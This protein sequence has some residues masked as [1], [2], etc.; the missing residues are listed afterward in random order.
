M[1]NNV[2]AQFGYFTVF[3]FTKNPRF[4]EHKLSDRLGIVSRTIDFGPAGRFFFYTS[5]GQTA[6]TEE[7]IALKIGFVRTP[8][9]SSLSAQHLLDRKLVSPEGVDQ[10]ALRGNALVGCFS[11][12][13]A[14][15]SIFKTLL[16]GLPLYY[17]VNEDGL[18]CSDRLR[19]LVEILDR[20]ELD[21]AAI[22]QHF[23]LL[24]TVGSQTY[25]RNVQ[26][27]RPGECLKWEEGGLKVRL[28]KDFRSFEEDPT[29]GSTDPRSPLIHQRLKDVIGA[30]ISSIQKSGSDFGNLLSGGVDSS[31]TQLLINENLPDAQHRSFSFLMHA[32]SFE[33]EVEYAKQAQLVFNTEHVFVDV[34]PKDYPDLLVR[35]IEILG[36]PVYMA[37]DPCKIALAE[38][39]A[40]DSNGP[41]YFFH[42]QGGDSV[43]GTGLARKIRWLELA[44]GIP[45]SALI[46]GSAGKLLKP[47][48]ARQS[49]MLRKAAIILKYPNHLMA[50]INTIVANA[51]YDLAL[52][53]FGEKAVQQALEL[54]RGLELEYLDSHNYQEKVH[55]TVCL[56]ALTHLASQEIALFM[57]SGKELVYPFMDEDVIRVSFAVRPERRYISG[58]RVKHILKDILEQRSAS[59]AARLPKRGSS[60]NPDVRTWMGS[61]PLY[62]MVRS[63]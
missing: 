8:A 38:S 19:C 47:I 32:P 59:P 26:L 22:P 45:A 61:G 14:R 57:A 24:S 17:S 63:I 35:S 9:R 25:F 7:A 30:Y 60:F 5:Y 1:N 46:L 12:T 21:E 16:S 42:S 2:S 3:G 62:E 6:E 50:P 34:F 11:K 44:S 39:L 58:S 4:L 15:F 33:P 37:I 29:F 54:K 49:Q 18:F 27:L 53:C 48:M 56:Q 10:H 51:D 43:F 36:Q 55:V 40:Q 13:E 28:V 52:R 23:L 20:L 41:H 31:F